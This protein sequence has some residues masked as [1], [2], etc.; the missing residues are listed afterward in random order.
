MSEY[1]GG[2]VTAQRP[3]DYFPRVDAGLCQRA[4]EEFFPTDQAVLRIQEE[5]RED[6]IA[7]ARKGVQGRAIGFRH[8]VLQLGWR[9]P[10]QLRG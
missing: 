10:R 2:A 4:A 3:A 7:K 1:D 9:E 8:R 6:F 5:D